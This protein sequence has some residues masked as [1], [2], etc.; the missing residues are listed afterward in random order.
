MTDP[1]SRQRG[2]PKRDRTVNFRHKYSTG[3]HHLV[4]SLKVGSTPRRTDWLTV[5]RKVTLTLTW[6]DLTIL[7]G[8]WFRINP[9]LEGITRGHTYWNLALQIAGV[10]NMINIIWSWVPHKS[11]WARLHWRGP[12][13]TENY[14]SV[15]T[16]E[17]APIITN[18]Q[19]SEDS[20]KS[21]EKNGKEEKRKLVHGS[22]MVAS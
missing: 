14:K 1:T 17:R 3:K 2:P 13:V 6:L 4:K 16:S 12:V 20:S 10:S 8:P 5:S 15:L 18:P 11:T 19:M 21:N 22:Q 7:I 9:M